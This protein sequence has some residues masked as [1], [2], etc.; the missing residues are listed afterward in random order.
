MAK[1]KYDKYIIEDFSGRPMNDIRAQDEFQ[2]ALPRIASPILYLDNNMIEGG[3]YS[4]VMWFH[5]ASD[6]QVEAHTHDYNEI[7]AFIGSDPKDVHNLGGELEFWLDDEK[8]ILKKS[9]MVFIPAGMKHSPL[10]L[11]RIDRPILHFSIMPAKVYDKNISK[12]G[13]K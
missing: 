2:K 6:V 4:E 9:C 13:K 3:F 1:T 8:H 11:R 12:S 10:V 5:T 7:L